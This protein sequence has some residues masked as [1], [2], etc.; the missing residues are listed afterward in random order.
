MYNKSSPFIQLRSVQP[1]AGQNDLFFFF[2]IERGLEVLGGRRGG[3]R[4]FCFAAV[5][6]PIRYFSICNLPLLGFTFLFFFFSP[7]LMV[8]FQKSN[9]RINVFW[10]FHLAL[11]TR[12]PLRFLVYK[13]I[14][15][16]FWPSTS[17]L[18]VALDSPYGQLKQVVLRIQAFGFPYLKDAFN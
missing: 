2:L 3:T 9:F 5:G 13:V 6:F 15:L 1:K 4:R 10:E 7:Y 8:I 16:F 11:Q 18:Q 17:Y 12:T 14:E